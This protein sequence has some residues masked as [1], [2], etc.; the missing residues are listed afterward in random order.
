MDQNAQFI[1]DL[2]NDRF[3]FIELCEH[4]EISPQDWIQ[5]G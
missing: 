2:L 5:M 4:Y 3:S 1:A